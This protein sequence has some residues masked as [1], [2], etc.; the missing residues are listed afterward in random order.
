MSTPVMSLR[1]DRS[2]R[3]TVRAVARALKRDPGLAARLTDLLDGRG[4][5]D[6]RRSVGPFVDESAALGF[7]VGRLV[8]E[9]RP[10][11]IWLFGSR[12][13]G[14]ARRDS[15]FDLLVVFPDTI[16]REAYDYFRA[17]A[18]V[19]SCGLAVDIVPCRKGDLDA[20][21]SSPGT[22]VDAAWREGRLVYSRDKSRYPL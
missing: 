22:I 20:D 6:A 13:R 15:D 14:D 7:L 21:R 1:V 8:A 16:G 12:A 2:L 11:E 10:E 9:L 18:P 17:R 4:D 19:S 3:D 5:G